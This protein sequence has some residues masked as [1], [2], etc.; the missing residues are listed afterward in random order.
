VFAWR[1]LNVPQ[2]WS[3]VGSGVSVAV[4]ALT[5]IPET[6]YPFVYIWVHKTKKEKTAKGD[7]AYRDQKVSLQTSDR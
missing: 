5:M 4:I 3:Y 6:I 7:V 2:N 1:Y